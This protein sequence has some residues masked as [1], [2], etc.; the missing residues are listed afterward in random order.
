MCVQTYI[1]TGLIIEYKVCWFVFFSTLASY[2]FYWL[3]SKYAFRRNSLTTAFLTAELSYL[4]FFIVAG[5]GSLFYA[6]QLPHLWGLISIGVILTLLYSLPLWPFRFVQKT[7]KPGFLKTVLLAFTWAYVITVLPVES[8]SGFDR[9]EFLL[10]FTTRFFFMLMLCS[11]FD[12][13]DVAMDQLYS[14]KTLATAVSPKTL[15]RVMAVTFSIYMFAGITMSLYF[16]N[17]KQM[18]AFSITAALLWYM[19]RLSLRKQGYLFYYF[20]VDGLMLFSS[21]AT[22]VAHWL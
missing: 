3:V 16:S 4:L 11:I 7:P 19:Y 6:L 14:L 5:F 15:Q 9:V 1:L 12:M 8:S 17:S 20:G 13:R 21:I 10:L 22:I 2:N 18:V